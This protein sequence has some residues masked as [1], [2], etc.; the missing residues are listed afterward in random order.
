[1]SVHVSRRVWARCRLVKGELLVMLA[2]A[3]CADDYGVCYPSEDYLALMTRQTER[4]VQRIIDRLLAKKELTLLRRGGGR[5]NPAKYELTPYIAKGDRESPIGD[6]RELPRIR[7]RKDRGA[8]KR[9]DPGAS[10]KGVP[11][12]KR[13]TLE[14][15]KGDPESPDPSCDPPNDPSSCDPS[16][17]NRLRRVEAPSVDEFFD[18]VLREGF[19]RIVDKSLDAGRCYTKWYAAGWKDGEG[20]PILNFRGLLR[21][22]HETTSRGFIL[23]KAVW[24]KLVELQ[25]E[26]CRIDGLSLDL[27]DA[28]LDEDAH[29]LEE[30]HGQ[31]ARNRLKDFINEQAR[32][33]TQTPSVAA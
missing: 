24:P 22:L 8:K 17:G 31:P 15:E 26:V 21:T 7:K 5:L 12:S 33:A 25:K 27:I 16:L 10:Q 32:L 11:E 20:K 29:K 4:A 2:L 3:D 14:T 19:V 18:F 30:D 1:M 23:D 9:G 6:I 13:A 28:T